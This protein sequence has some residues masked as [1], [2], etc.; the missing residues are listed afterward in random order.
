M[1]SEEPIPVT[2]LTGFLGSGKSTLLSRA[3]VAPEMARALV[4]I[5]EFGDVGL[6]HHL[7]E[8]SSDDTILLANGCLCCTIRGNL[9]D[10]LADSLAHVASGRLAPFDR[11]IVETSG[12]ADPFLLLGFVLGVPAFMARYRPEAVVTVVDAIGYAALDRHPEAV[13]Q[14]LAADRV[15]ISKT[16]IAPPEAI[17]GAHAAVQA[18]NPAAPTL[19][20]SPQ[21]VT[22]DMI[23]GAGPEPRWAPGPGHDHGPAHHATVLGHRDVVARSYHFSEPVTDGALDRLTEALAGAIDERVLRIKAIL[24]RAGSGTSAVIH[25]VAGR[26]SPLQGLAGS[27]GDGKLVIIARGDSLER[28]D[29]I[30]AAAGGEALPIV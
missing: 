18:L 24:P 16:D 29:P 23:M 2:I 28:F 25:A 19:Q 5:N 4:V 9:V 27:R 22:P 17:E 15:I 11:V 20:S 21:T 8:A 7:I 3:L 14:V 1:N 12:L 30:V 6:D 26:L 13:S 10:T